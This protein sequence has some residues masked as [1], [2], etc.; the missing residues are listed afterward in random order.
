MHKAYFIILLIILCIFSNSLIVSSV[1]I[2]PTKIEMKDVLRGYSYERI[3]SVFNS[4]YYNYTYNL[5]VSGEASEW[6]K[7]YDPLDV[8]RSKPITNITIPSRSWKQVILSINVSNDTAVGVYNATVTATAFTTNAT[9]SGQSV[10]IGVSMIVILHVVGKQN[11]TGIVK[12]VTVKNA[13]VGYPIRFIVEFYNTGNVVARPLIIVNI[14]KNDVLVDTIFY[15]DTKVGIGFTKSISVSWDTSGR[16]SGGYTANITV[17]LGDN[18]IYSNNFNFY[19]LPYGSQ[20]R[21]GEIASIYYVGDLSVGKIVKIL[22]VFEN[23]GEIATKAKFVGEVYKN[24][25]LVDVIESEEIL[26]QVREN[27]TLTAYLKINSPG[28]YVVKGK[29]V[30]ENK[31]TSIVNLSFNVD[32]IFWKIALAIVFISFS[33]F[34]IIFILIKKRKINLSKSFLGLLTDKIYKNKI[35]KK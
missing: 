8:N 18:N 6:I 27:K 30:Y 34:S 26:V 31:E 3:F 9:Q 19:I 13:E 1:G 28:K 14:T 21:R 22:V 25:E 5:N 2:S 20:T 35:K 12:S 29:V 4:R 23:T 17:L 16:V 15:S 33:V 7:L 32:N 11:L 24:D 10:N